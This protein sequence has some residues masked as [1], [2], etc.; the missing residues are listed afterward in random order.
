MIESHSNPVTLEIPPAKDCVNPALEFIDCYA[1]G[2]GV[3]TERRSHL[4]KA[5][6][7]ALSTVIK[8]NAGEGENRIGI[9]LFESQGNLYVK[10]LNRGVPIFLNSNGTGAAFHDAAQHLDKLTIENEGRHGQSVVMG[11][12]LG[13]EAVKKVMEELDDKTASGVFKEEDIVVREMLPGEE[14][15]LSKLFYFVYGYDYINEFIYYPEKLRKMLDD[16]TLISIVA[17]L[18]NGRILAHVGLL[19]WGE[20]PSVYE[21]CLGVVDPRVKSRGLFGQ[22]FQRTMDRVNEISMQYCFFDFVTN[23]DYSQRFVSRY[24][25]AEMAL[26]V[27]C[28]SKETQAKLEKLGLG[29]DPK[30][31]DR[32]TLL[33][34]VI[35][36]VKY[37]FGKEISLPNNL[38]ELLGFLLKPLNI[39]WHPAPRFQFLPPQGEYKASLQPA[40]NA[41]VFDLFKAGR[42]AVDKI[43]VDWHQLLRNGYR[44]G[45][46]EVP[47]TEQGL[48]NLYDILAAHGFFVAGFVPYH[49]SGTLGLRFQSIGPTKVAFDEIKVFTEPAKRLLQIVRENYE[50]NEIL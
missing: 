36:R 14:V 18:P 22:V 50:R 32:Y 10:V 44:Y 11:M 28:Q 20:S 21:P 3:Q 30:E 13:E 24:G 35:P 42:S 48:G 49:H 37:P 19:K 38:G 17:A 5:S 1:A 41:V 31:M 27:G 7:I 43:L 47:V 33:L 12:R 40:Q 15:E 4:K 16:K 25:T 45:A 26:F 9:S 8:N 34:S 46:I 2:L 23:H 29:P 39:S 6:Q